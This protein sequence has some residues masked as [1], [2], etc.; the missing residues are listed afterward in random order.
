MWCAVLC[1]TYKSE[2]EFEN[3]VTYSSTVTFTETLLYYFDDP[4]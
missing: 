1:A 3:M 2:S 4:Y